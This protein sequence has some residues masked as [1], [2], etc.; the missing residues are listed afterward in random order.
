MVSMKNNTNK[1]AIYGGLGNQMFQYALHLFLKSNGIKSRISLTYFL[2][3]D[4]HNGFDLARAFNIQL[5]FKHRILFFLMEYGNFLIINKY[6]NFILR[7]TV[8]E[9]QKHNLA[10][11]KEKEE[12]IMDKNILNVKSSYIVGSWQS[13]LY[14]NNIREIVLKEFT[15]TR[16]NDNNN[17]DTINL[18]ENTNSVSIHVRR[19]DYLSSQWNIT[20][21]VIKKMDYYYKAIQYINSHVT[22]PYFF[23]FSDD[24]SWTKEA[25]NGIP[26]TKYISFNTTKKNYLD[27]YLMS[28]C[29][30]NIIANSTFSWW[31]AWLN[32]NTDKIVISPNI[33]LNGVDCSELI[34]NEWKLIEV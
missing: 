9:I 18:I 21:H 12:F 23:I 17:R 2:F 5:S 28:I 7:K 22:V 26:N 27:M 3:P 34:P 10:I 15:F 11:Y 31:G 4:D 33:W 14:F 32:Q 13:Y 1:I 24:I 20:H 6:V 19:G 16:P 29:K 30:H 8:P 25:L